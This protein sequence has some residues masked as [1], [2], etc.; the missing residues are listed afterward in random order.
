[1]KVAQRFLRGQVWFIKDKNPVVEAGV[2]AYDRPVIIVS[3]DIGNYS[4]RF[5]LAVPFTS[6]EKKYQPTHV[7][8]DIEGV[9]TTALC[10]SVRSVS[11]DCLYNYQYTLTNE[12]MERVEN[13]LLVA[14]G[15]KNPASL[16]PSEV[17]KMEFPWKLEEETI[18]D[19]VEITYANSKDAVHR[20]FEQVE[21]ISATEIHQ[22]IKDRITETNYQSLYTE[23][24]AMVRD[25][26]LKY[27]NRKYFRG[28]E[29]YKVV[30]PEPTEQSA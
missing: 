13:A 6:K 10:E 16:P 28:T 15:M 1:M 8:F 14:M 2:I 21:G 18:T 30:K 19:A 5:V 23:L 24:R 4:A 17:L 27:D 22:Q 29:F 20:L 3:N 25:N 26:I 9:K 7:Y 12:T 11:M